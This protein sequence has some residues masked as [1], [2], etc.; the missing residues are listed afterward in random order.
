MQEQ[1]LDAERKFVE[2]EE[3]REN[4]LKEQGITCKKALALADMVT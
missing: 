1:R 2:E 4:V 3:A